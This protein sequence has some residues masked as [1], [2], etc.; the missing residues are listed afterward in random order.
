MKVEYWDADQV[1]VGGIQPNLILG[2][3][4][5]GD[6]VF[7]DDK[8]PDIAGSPLEDLQE[9][10]PLRE[11]DWENVFPINTFLKQID[12][13]RAVNDPRRRVIPPLFWDLSGM[14]VLHGPI[15]TAQKLMGQR[16]YLECMD[17]PELVRDFLDWIVEAYITV[18]ELFASRAGLEITSVHIGECSGCMVGGQQFCEFIQQPCQ[19]LIDELGPGRVHSCG[20]SDHLLAGIANLQNLT[21]I[22]TGSNTSVAKMREVFG[23]DF[24]IEIAPDAEM[25]CFGS[26]D[27]VRRWVESTLEENRGGPLMFVYHLDLGYPTENVLVIHDVLIERGYVRPGRHRQGIALNSN[28]E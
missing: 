13:L 22:N 3:V 4:L 19:K 21:A 2:A 11:I 16:I 24:P 25:L 7:F 20:Q 1:L 28:R 10:G 14:A 27:D 12:R 17:N 18:A 23:P 26:A 9:V 6:L 5:G 15:T 8:D